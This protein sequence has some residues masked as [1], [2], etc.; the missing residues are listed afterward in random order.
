MTVTHK[1]LKIL[2]GHDVANGRTD[3]RTDGQTDERHTII[4]P[5]FHF[6]RIKMKALGLVVLDK[7]SFENC[8]FIF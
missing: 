6:G 5:K 3:R 1:L 8:I 7:K 2:R 4:C